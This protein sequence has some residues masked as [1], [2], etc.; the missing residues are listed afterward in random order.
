MQ[1]N[2]AQILSQTPAYTA[3]AYFNSAGASLMSHAVR[4]AMV[5][6]LHRESAI[7]AYGAAAAMSAELS[8]LY[9]LAAQLLGCDSDEIALTEGHASGWRQIIGAMTFSQ[10]DRILVGRSEWGG[11]Y[12]ALAHIAQRYKA[13]IEVIPS[14]EFGEVCMEQLKLMLDTR[15]RLISLTWLPANGG[16][17]NP[18][19]EV[20]A[21]AKLAG[22]PFILDAAQ[23]LGQLPID[24]QKIGCDVLTAP[25]RKWLRGPRGTGLMYVRRGFLSQLI[26]AVIDQFSAPFSGRDYTLRN[27]ARRF[28]TSEACVAARLG[29]RKAIQSALTLG[30]GPI[31]NKI[32]Q[33]A[34]TIR[35]GLSSI[36]HVH[37]HDLGQH[38]SGLVSFTVSGMNANDVRT[39]LMSAGVEVGLNGISLT[40]LDMQARGLTDILRASPHVYTTR[41]DIEKLLLVTESIAK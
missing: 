8:E 40:P 41:E 1:I 14:N 4:N 22:I 36:R 16:L 38:Q 13:I 10:G 35:K 2:T 3:G 24:V 9:S 5:E 25:G 31:Q 21:L 37:L 15:V 32:S 12:A 26:P 33:H 28:E 30:I 20:G 6:H 11:N 39:R 23:A 19:A 7:G 29:L 27:D 34:N 17:I 18:A